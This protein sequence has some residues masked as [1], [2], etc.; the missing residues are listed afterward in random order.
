MPGRVETMP[1]AYI[2]HWAAHEAWIALETA[3]QHHYL[4]NK[5]K[6]LR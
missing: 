4:N 2:V 1:L 3:H 6:L 5:F